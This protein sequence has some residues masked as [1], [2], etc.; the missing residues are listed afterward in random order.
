MYNSPL[1]QS[2]IHWKSYTEN[3]RNKQLIHFKLCP[4][5]SSVMKSQ[6]SRRVQPEMWTVPLSGIS[7]LFTLPCFSHVAA[8]SLIRPA[9][10]YSR[11][12][13]NDLILLN[14]VLQ[15]KSSDACNL[16]MPEKSE[17]LPLSEKVQVLSLIR[18]FIISHYHKK[19]GEYST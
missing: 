4:V 13:S 12:V 17:V 9:L 7:M 18:C 3:S 8:T 16:N 14:N 10:R 6:V 5:L 15:R 2:I 19:S 11:D 1:T